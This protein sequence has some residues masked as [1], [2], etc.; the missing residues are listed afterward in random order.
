MGTLLIAGPLALDDHPEHPRLIG[1]VGGYAAIAAAPLAP[2]QLWCRGGIDITHQMK[3]LLEKRHI[4]LAGVAWEGPTPRGS[5]SGFVAGGS[6]L[7][8]DM[9]PTSA[10]GL[11]GALLIGLPPDEM[12]RALRVITALPDGEKR[13]LI[14]S[15]RPADLADLNF[16]RELLAVTD[17]LV[18]SASKALSLT[19][20]TSAL[21]AAQAL[22]AE[23]A[24]A[25][26]LTASQLGGLI[27]YQGKAT[28]Y[29]AL[30]VPALDKLGVSAAFPGALAAWIAGTGRCDFSTLKRG[31]AMASGVAGIC[32]QG[33]GPKK[34]LQANRDDYMERFN[35]LRR[36]QKY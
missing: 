15:P 25:V 29:P 19:G 14:V 3:D 24:K 22:Q 12:R 26:V 11:G 1:G 16:R 33:I 23:G 7:P 32:A 21:G 31:C 35:R 4:D 10:D 9:E 2:T 6:L 8:I 28:T 18:L 27:S 20:E 17:V 36:D 30:P 13:I 5:A 34:L